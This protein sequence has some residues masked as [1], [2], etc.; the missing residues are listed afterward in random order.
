MRNVPFQDPMNRGARVAGWIYLPLHVVA[1]PLL[2]GTVLYLLTGDIPSEIT[3][4]VWYYLVGLTFVFVTMWG[5]LRRS[6]H[7]LVERLSFCCM[8]LLAA[9]AVDVVLSLALRLGMAVLGDL[10]EPNNEAVLAL[11]GADYKRM[12]AVAVL[13]APV[14]EE[15]LFRGVLFGA[16]RGKNRFLAYFVSVVVFSLYHVWQYALVDQNPMLLLGALR[17]VPVSIALAYCYDRTQS[18][19]TPIFFHMFINT[20]SL[21][22]MTAT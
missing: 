14:V 15:C 10:P 13:M 8:S 3:A 22:V 21:S 2:L 9:Y 18:I 11:A 1:I 12:F 6:F 5:F 19:W 4:N 20:L 17:Y 7:V 16:I